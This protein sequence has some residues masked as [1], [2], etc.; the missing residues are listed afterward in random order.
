MKTQIYRTMRNAVGHKPGAAPVF[1]LRRA[2]RLAALLAFFGITLSAN[3]Q[4]YSLDWYKIAPGGTSA[5]G[6]YQ[7]SG[8]IGQADA[9]GPLTGGSYVLTGGFW[10][11]VWAIQ[12][13]GAPNLYICCSANTVTVSW[14]NVPGCSLQQNSNLAD[15]N[16]WT[17]SGYSC[18]TSNGTNYV[19]I[20]SPTGNMFFRLRRQ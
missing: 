5:A 16:G 6:T 17:T 13:P 8:A 19:T 11:G 18:A 7:V 14:Q 1:S 3:A 15:P 9:S 12:T 20:T 4:S 10:S 2:S